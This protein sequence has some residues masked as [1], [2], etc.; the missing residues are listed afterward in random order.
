MAVLETDSFSLEFHEMWNITELAPRAV[1]EAG[2]GKRIEV[3]SYKLNG[4]GTSKELSV[5][6]SGIKDNILSVFGDYQNKYEAR[7]DLQQPT[8]P[9]SE[10]FYQQI[11]QTEDCNTGFGLYGVINGKNAL[12]VTVEV[13]LSEDNAPY[14]I[15]EVGESLDKIVWAT[16]AAKPWW[17]FW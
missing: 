10:E 14:Y 4:N 13:P 7:I 1:L 12:L 17:K 11:F 16:Q 15:L 9:N 5:A 6:M 8:S 2:E 3:S